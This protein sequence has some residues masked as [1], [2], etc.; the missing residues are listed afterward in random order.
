MED[1]HG[2]FSTLSSREV[3]PGLIPAS[4]ICNRLLDGL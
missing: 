2:P 1:E 3:N 4:S